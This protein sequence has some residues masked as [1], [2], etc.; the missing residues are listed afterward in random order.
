MN[1]FS[2]VSATA[3]LAVALAGLLALFSTAATAAPAAP[4]APAASDLG[5]LTSTVSGTFTDAAGAGTFTGTFVPSRFATAGD[6]ISADGVLTGDLVSA[7]GTTRQVTQNQT[8]LN[9]MTGADFGLPF[10][11]KSVSF[12]NTSGYFMTFAPAGGTTYGS[13]G[14]GGGMAPQSPTGQ[15][16]LPP[17]R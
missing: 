14:T 5:S 2:R 6:R 7:D 10:T 15:R 17:R 1:R 9:T 11:G 4:A 12:M 16:P 13:F 3:V 8:D